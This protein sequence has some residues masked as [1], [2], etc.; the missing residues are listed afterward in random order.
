MAKTHQRLETSAAAKIKFHLIEVRSRRMSDQ[1]AGNI[2]R[3]QRRNSIAGADNAAEPQIAL[4]RR[5]AK[6]SLMNAIY[7]DSG[8]GAG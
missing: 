8:F 2:L 4:S 1:E 3:R 7:S 6:R 5:G